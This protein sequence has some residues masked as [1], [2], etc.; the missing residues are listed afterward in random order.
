MIWTGL[1]SYESECISEYAYKTGT[2][3]VLSRPDNE[4]ARKLLAHT[5]ENIIPPFA[6]LDLWIKQKML[7]LAAYN[8]SVESLEN[9][10]VERVKTIDRKTSAEQRLARLKA[11]PGKEKEAHA[12]EAELFALYKEVE[13]STAVINIAA[14]YMC[15]IF[16][17]LFKRRQLLLFYRILERLFNS[18][19]TAVNKLAQA[20]ATLLTDKNLKHF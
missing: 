4:P 16:L 2:K 7:E 12:T 17:P 19:T 13:N 10:L 9:M 11:V 20:W 8:K 1:Q 18:E 15:E 14:T 3:L 5:E 6:E